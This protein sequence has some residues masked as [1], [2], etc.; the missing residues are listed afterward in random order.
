MSKEVVS[1]VPMPTRTSDLFQPKCGLLYR[2]S[3]KNIFLFLVVQM[4]WLLWA[5]PKKMS[6][7]LHHNHASLQPAGP[8][9]T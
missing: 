9:S 2:R 8:F 5:K 3:R 1:L 7:L 4:G 6:S